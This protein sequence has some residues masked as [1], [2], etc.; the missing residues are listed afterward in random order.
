MDRVRC[1]GLFRRNVIGAGAGSKGF[2]WARLDI[3]GSKAETDLLPGKLDPT[4]DAKHRILV[5]IVAHGEA[6]LRES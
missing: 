6:P 4:E 2:P 5:R 3:R 1:Q